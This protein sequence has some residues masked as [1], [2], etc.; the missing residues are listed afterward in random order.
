M[1]QKTK[2]V[3]EHR[4]VFSDGRGN[5]LGRSRICTW[6]LVP[7]TL[8]GTVAGTSKAAL[9]E[10]A[11]GHADDW[12]RH[13]PRRPVRPMRMTVTLEIEQGEGGKS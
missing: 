6:R 3:V 13:H 11:S 4:W 10:F 7:P 9:M 2:R 1:T 5:A 8:H 12:N